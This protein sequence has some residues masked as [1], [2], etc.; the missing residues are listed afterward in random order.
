M[1][2]NKKHNSRKIN[3]KGVF[4][5]RR[6]WKGRIIS[7]FYWEEPVQWVDFSKIGQLCFD[8]LDWKALVAKFYF[9]QIVTSETSFV[10]NLS[11][12]TEMQ[13]LETSEEIREKTN[14]HI[15]E[16]NRSRLGFQCKVTTQKSVL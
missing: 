12:G 15:T 8:S 1:E 13:V 7:F 10:D 11:K 3:W 14:L 16:E 2:K 9:K 4:E 6:E 5:G